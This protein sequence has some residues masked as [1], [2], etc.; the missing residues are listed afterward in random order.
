M[1][2]NTILYIIII[3]LVFA[4]IVGGLF[5]F[6]GNKHR[7]NSFSETGP[8]TSVPS[9]IVTEDEN[10]SNLSEQPN[11][12]KF[13]EYFTEAYLAKLPADSEFK[14]FEII[15]TKT[16]TFGEQFCSSLTMKKQIPANTLSTAI[17]DV[18]AKIDAQPRGGKFPQALGPLPGGSAGPTIGCEPLIQSAGKYEYKVYL[19][20][21]LVIVLPFEVK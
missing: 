16:F 15:K 6:L 11:K 10:E 2:N 12:E 18:N 13:N 14:P 3:I 9:T 1:K 20:D 17:Y 7:E 5:Y 4:L 8:S 19:N 21:I